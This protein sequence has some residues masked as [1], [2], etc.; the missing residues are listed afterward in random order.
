MSAGCELR[1]PDVLLNLK[2]RERT[3]KMAVFFIIPAARTLNLTK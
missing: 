3:L 2:C 1:T